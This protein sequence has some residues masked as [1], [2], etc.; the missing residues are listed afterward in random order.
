MDHLAEVPTTRPFIAAPSNNPS[1][2]VDK[3]L[4]LSVS[5]DWNLVS[6]F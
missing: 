1:G 5:D 4:Y 6:E 2:A 3:D